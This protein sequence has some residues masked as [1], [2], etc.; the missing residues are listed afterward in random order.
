MALRRG[1]VAPLLVFAL[2]LAITASADAATTGPL[3]PLPP[4]H[5]GNQCLPADTTTDGA[6]GKGSGQTWTFGGGGA[7]PTSGAGCDG[8]AP[9]PPFDTSR[10]QALYWGIDGNNP[11]ALSLNNDN[12]E[13]SAPREFMSFDAA[14]S[15]LP[16]GRLVW[17]AH[18]VMNC[19]VAASCGG[20]LTAPVDTE[21]VLTITD[22]GGS[23]QSLT[24]P[25]DAGISNPEVGGVIAVTPSLTNFKANFLFKAKFTS[26]TDPNGYQPA[27]DWY[28]A[29][30]GGHPSAP[31]G[32][33]E[34][35]SSFSGAF[36]YVNRPP[37][38][39]FSCSPASPVD[40]D[41][42]TCTANDSDDGP[43]SDL[44]EK[45][46][47]NGNGSTSDPEDK[48]GH[49]VSGSFGPGAHNVSLHVID[50]DGAETVVTK[51]ITVA[52]RVTQTTNGG[53]TPTTGSA[54]TTPPVVALLVPKQKLASIFK[55]GLA[56]TL[57]SNERGVAKLKLTIAA[58]LAKQLK[59]KGPVGTV[60]VTL[61]AP[62]KTAFKVKLS[63]KA[64]TKLKKLKKIAFTLSG[65]VTDAA[66]NNSSVKRS[67][68][69][70][71]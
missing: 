69:A 12:I 8:T 37:S 44:Q 49:S 71:R 48:S 66:G 7:T 3:Y 11:P 63:K 42:V 67:F 10:F 68:Q 45:W 6:S 24:A 25:A 19:S 31:A 9:P 57:A 59:L 28:N 50:G 55:K 39:D 62:G 14:L 16:H 20:S 51:T 33:S 47:W 30:P 18:T 4:S 17:R 38:A 1:L 58:K 2:L 23:P 26:N 32:H 70:K 35:R 60:T 54:D 13:E 27:L 15:D 40:G 52:A 41:T 36:Y 21:L 29:I 34:T 65:T 46:D 22:M 43:S 53:P 64:A 5:G 61:T 56:G